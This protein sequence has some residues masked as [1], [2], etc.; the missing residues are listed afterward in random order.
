MHT[1]EHRQNEGEA[2]IFRASP[3]WSDCPKTIIDIREIIWKLRKCIIS[4]SELLH[5]HHKVCRS[6][7]PGIINRMKQILGTFIKIEHTE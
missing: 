6:N 3:V 7:Q 5:F 4:R 2:L 1:P